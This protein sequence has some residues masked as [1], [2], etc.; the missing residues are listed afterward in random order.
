M[1]PLAELFAHFSPAVRTGLRST[2]VVNLSTELALLEGNLL[3]D[4]S[5]LTKPRI[6]SVFTQETFRHH[7]KINIFKKDTVS[8]I[9][10]LMGKLEP[11]L[12]TLSP[13]GDSSARQDC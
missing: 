11:C 13:A 6:E 1:N 2:S 9:T 7:P 3:G 4:V 5:E 12:L 8:P 10:E